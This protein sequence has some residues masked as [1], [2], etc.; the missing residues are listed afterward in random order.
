MITIISCSHSPDDERVY[1]KQVRS[2]EKQGHKIFYITR[3]EFEINLSSALIYHINY[4]KI[5]SLK[6]YIEFVINKIKAQDKVTHVQIHETELLSILKAIKLRSK[7]ITTIYDV[8]EDME[9][10]YRTFSE[11]SW[12]LKEIAI[13]I[14]KLKEKKYLKY[15][16]QIILANSPI[17]E[18]PY[19][20][21]CIPTEIIQNFPEKKYCD[22]SQELS[23]PQKPKFIYHGH[24]GPERGI[25]DLIKAMSE[26]VNYA[27]QATLTLVGTFRTTRFRDKIQKLINDYSFENIV[28]ISNQIPHNEIWG[29]LKN[30]TIGVIPFGRNPLTEKNTPTKLFEMM[31]SGLIIVSTD[32]PPVRQFVNESVYWA[33]PENPGS[34]GGAMINAIQSLGKFKSIKDNLD[35]IEKQYN[36]G[37]IEK[38]Y[39][40]LFEL[41]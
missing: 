33:L 40:E 29:V 13:K 12:A 14:R 30:H 37:M 31:A 18:T 11:R 10:L 27:P 24:L 19:K 5:S 7:N 26:V 32:L 41:R 34:L 3:S 8:H 22:F 20:E 35:L 17:G 1:H 28:E 6:K 15:V 16:D 38:R 4:K 25:D 36:W 2:L 21:Y 9:A 39:L 23:L